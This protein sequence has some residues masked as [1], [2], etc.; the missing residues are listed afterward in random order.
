MTSMRGLISL[1]KVGILRG[2]SLNPYEGQYFKNS[3]TTVSKPI[4]ITTFDN[5]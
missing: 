4:G 3:Q 2:S 1:R 5:P